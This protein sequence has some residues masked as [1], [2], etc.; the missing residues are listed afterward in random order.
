MGSTSL[1]IDMLL[2]WSRKGK[3]ACDGA[4]RR[5]YREHG[6]SVLQ[7]N[8][9]GS[10]MTINGVLVAQFGRARDLPLFESHPKLVYPV[11]LKECVTNTDFTRW[12]G[13]L[14]AKPDDHEADALVA[15]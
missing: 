13:P 9:L 1:G 5:C 10:A 6:Q 14:I 8:S 2:A 12:Y 15:A 7:Q 11:W 4:L 3:R